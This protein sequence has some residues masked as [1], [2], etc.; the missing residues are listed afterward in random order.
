MQVRQEP[1]SALP[2]HTQIPI[3]FT[4]G[5]VFEVTTRPNGGFDLTER[6]IDPPYIKDYDAIEPP[7]QWTIRFDVTNWGLL[8]A[9]RD[10]MRIG[11]AVIAFDTLGVDLLEGRNDLALLWDLRVH[12]DARGQGVGH[13]LFTAVADWAKANGCVQL[14]VETQNINV[15]ACRFYV[16]QGCELR[17]VNRGAYNSFRDEIQLL[18]YKDLQEQ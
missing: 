11:R 4:V 17:V 10:G 7:A 2:Q 1:I 15:P 14:K 18:W 3:A 16:R 8:A 6:Q 5:C 9:Y 12:P 13:A